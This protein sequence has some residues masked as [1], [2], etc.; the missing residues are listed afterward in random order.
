MALQGLKIVGITEAQK[1]KKTKRR[2]LF[3]IGLNIY[4]VRIFIT[5]DGIDFAFVVAAVAITAAVSDVD[6]DANAN[7]ITSFLTF[8]FQ[9]IFHQ[10]KILV[11]FYATVRI[12]SIKVSMNSIVSK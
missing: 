5:S 3:H 11:D 7:A 9:K 12:C 1:K 8:N 6:V 2:K 4:R 10:Y